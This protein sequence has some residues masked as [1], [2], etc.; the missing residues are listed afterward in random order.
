MADEPIVDAPGPEPEPEGVV[1]LQGQKVVPL[2]ALTAE[3]ERVR[4]HTEKKIRDELEP[5][6]Q[7]AAAADQLQA[8][9]TALQPHID[10]LK[11]HPEVM[12]QDH[13]PKVPDVSDDEAEKEARDLELYTPT[14]LDLGRAKRIIAK[15]RAE[16]K[17]AAAEAATAAV[18]PMLQTNAVQAARQNFVWAASQRDANGNALIDPQYLAEIWAQCPAELTANPEA[19]RTIL[20]AAIGRATVQGKRPQ[21]GSEPLFTEP[22]GGRPGSGYTMSEP[23]RKIAKNVGL[24]DKQWAESAKSYQP[25]ATNVLG[26]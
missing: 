17:A 21:H 4:T 23:E 18:Q 6:K 14:G 24:S 3:R 10:Y 11:K 19:A 22:S 20:E 15:R 2:A 12:Q 5:F 9:L 7:R 25:D 1:E 13:E 16:T 26:D 8:D